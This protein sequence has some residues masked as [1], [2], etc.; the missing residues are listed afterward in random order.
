[1]LTRAP[2]PAGRRV[3]VVS[4]S[5][6]QGG[7]GADAAAARGLDTPAFSTE[8][9]ARLAAL[10]PAGAS[11]SNPVDLAGAGEADLSAY[12]DLCEI[13]L[14][15]G[16]VDA[17]VLSGYLGCYGEDNPAIE[18]AELAVV[19]RLGEI[20]GA[21][22]APLVVH[23]MSA[24]S[25]AVGRMWEHQ[26]PAFAGI[27]FAMSAL[28]AAARLHDFPGRDLKAP[29]TDSWVPRAGYWAARDLLGELGV[30]MPAGRVVR[31]HADLTDCSDMTFPVALKAGWLEHKSEHRGVVLGIDSPTALAAAYDEMHGRLGA[32]EYVVEEQDTRADPIEML[33]G[34]RRDRDFGPIVVVGA[35]GTRAELHRDV[36]VE[37]APVDHDTARGMIDRLRCR[38]LLAG[39]RGA[40][41]V[42]VDALAAIVVAVSEAI[43]SRT[44]ISDLELNP[45]RVAPGGALAVDALVVAAESTGEVP[46]V[47]GAQW[48]GKSV[49][50]DEGVN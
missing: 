1:M 45:V 42:D 41:P 6:G 17:V 15:S 22:H 39:W 47:D 28:A 16:E 10:L 49:Y 23:S 18:A 4:D 20:V 13:L 33:V 48:L 21:H 14:D 27:E 50:T 26:I 35:G 3:A 34:A 12:A 2:V 11:V 36:C 44:G 40:P 43:A 5:G 7:I 29:A 46:V 24:G 25:A 31:E 8:L 9:Q 19:D 32:G 37:L 30:S 38:P